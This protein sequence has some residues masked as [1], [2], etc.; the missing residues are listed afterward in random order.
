MEVNGYIVQAEAYRTLLERGQISEEE[1]KRKIAVF[2]FLGTCT[3]DQIY[4]LFDSSAFNEIVKE[5]VKRALKNAGTDGETS[6]KILQELRWLFDNM[7]AKE[8]S[9]S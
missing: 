5:Y 2:A 6:E 3:K 7:S 4:D 8:I 1:A 9:E